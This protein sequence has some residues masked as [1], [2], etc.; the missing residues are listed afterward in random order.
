MVADVAPGWKTMRVGC[1]VGV[2]CGVSGMDGGCVGAGGSGVAVGGCDVA[3]GGIGVGGTGVAVGG[4]G[5]AVG[6][7]GV[8]GMSTVVGGCEPVQA[9]IM[10]AKVKS[11]SGHRITFLFISSAPC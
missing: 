5:V 2:V 10:T 4:T 3:V 7:A 8:C 1:T 6:A 9:L 11:G